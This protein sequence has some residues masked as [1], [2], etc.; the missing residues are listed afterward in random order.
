MNFVDSG[1]RS[2]ASLS[3]RAD[4]AAE[5]VRVSDRASRRARARPASRSFLATKGA[6]G[7]SAESY[8][9]G[10]A[11]PDWRLEHG[12]YEVTITVRSGQIAVTKVF[13]L[14]DL[15]EDFSKFKLQTSA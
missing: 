7:F 13:S 12:E 9:Y 1:S 10:F 11:K 15:D 4:R 6:F 5:E 8:E 14:A 2:D 3:V